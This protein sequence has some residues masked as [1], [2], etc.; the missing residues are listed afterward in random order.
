VTSPAAPSPTPSRQALL[1]GAAGAA[2]SATVI[3]FGGTIALV[4]EAGHVLGATQAEITSWVTGICLGVAATTLGLSLWFK[5]PIVTAWSTPGAALII[6]ASAGLPFPVAIAA[7][8]IAGLLAAGIGLLPPLERAIAR[9]PQPIAA[10]MLAGVLLPF[11]LAL[12]TNAT[13]DPIAVGV[14][15][16]TFIVARLFAPLA[17]LLLVLVAAGVLLAIRGEFPAVAWSAPT[18]L[19]IAPEWQL[20]P[21]VGLAVPLCIA[22][23]VAQNLPGLAV[24]QASGY[25]PPSRASITAT[26]L[27]TALLAPTGVHGIN[28]AA[29]SASLCTGPDAYPDSARRY[30]VGVFYAASYALLAV[31]AGPLVGMFTALP[32]PVLSAVAGLALIGPLGLA[33]AG[34]LAAP[35]RYREAVLITVLATASGV[36]PLGIAAPF[37]GLAIGLAL[38]GLTKWRDRH[39]GDAR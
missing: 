32:R 24:L 9:I 39:A 13:T 27:A 8:V 2:L 10:A 1:L 11:G 29:I 36:S 28:L 3:G 12:F 6:G 31:L 17:A 18:L 16:V 4:V 7:F 14:L 38:F 26:G 33:L 37:W 19:V 23:M 15:L 35:T 21:A 34:S 25:Q 30:I 22:T 5:M 20:W